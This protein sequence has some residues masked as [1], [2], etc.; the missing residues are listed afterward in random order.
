MIGGSDDPATGNTEAA[1]PDE[2]NVHIQFAGEHPRGLDHIAGPSAVETAAE[3]TSALRH[4]TVIVDSAGRVSYFDPV[5]EQLTGFTRAEIIGRDVHILTGASVPLTSS[6][7]TRLAAKGRSGI[8]PI[9]RADGSVRIA[10]IRTHPIPLPDGSGAYILQAID[11]G[12][13]RATVDHLG[14]L[15]AFF[16]QSMFGFVMLDEH[17]RYLMLNQA[18]ADLNRRPI[19]DHIGRH[20]RE[21][22]DSA[23]LDEYEVLLGEVLRTGEPIVD[24]RIPGS[25]TSL[26]GNQQVWSA[27]W[28]RVTSWR[29]MPLGLCGI[30]IDVSEA[31]RP[32]L[33]AARGRDRLLLL[34]RIGAQQGAN[35]DMH[36]AAQDLAT[37][38]TAE[39]CD[40][41]VMDVLEEVVNGE[42][43]PSAIDEQ[44]L[45][46]RLG[47]AARFVDETT[48]RLINVQNPRQAFETHGFATVL[49]DN[50]AQLIQI[51]GGRIPEV[52]DPSG[53]VGDMRE[54]GAHSFIVAPLRARDVTLGALSCMRMSD[55]EPFDHDDLLL[56]QEIANRTALAVDNSRLYREEKQ[57]AL[58]LQLSL[59]PERLPQAPEADLAYRYLP[60]SRSRQ[61]GGDWFDAMVLPG[62]RLCLVVGDVIGHGIAAAA[63]MGRYR[64]AVQSLAS[65]GL[66]PAAL[67]TRLNDIAL[68]F[69]DNA[70]A[71]CMYVLYDPLQHRCAIASAGHPPIIIEPPGGVAYPLEIQSGP[72]L[73]AIPGAEYRSEPLN[74]PPGTRLLLYS[75]GVVESR[76]TPLDD[77]IKRLLQQLGS[78]RS[79]SEQCD[80]IMAAT[81]PDARDDRTILMAELYGLRRAD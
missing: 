80:R 7:F 28:Y 15:D 73:G 32:V 69:G 63:A 79:L 9:R 5:A 48:E 24:V 19:A 78:R 4:A 12:D 65:I 6:E 31:E 56:A 22:M 68:T 47:G 49:R 55:R 27:S 29:D 75:D 36:G 77:G 58:I 13:A 2:G 71:T 20:I 46:H 44:S 45:L 33:D 39:F 18:L 54:L 66:E 38:L 30:I 50:R 62:R 8:I 43:V 40:L 52:D 10:C 70:M 37:L 35:L 42:T 3:F 53:R 23:D 81:P 59:L 74:T 41:A 76:S 25:P 60:N 57:A 72:M 51:P 26:P 11:L 61:A 16:H 67:L 34:S 21:V 1:T 14:G 17:L 64:T